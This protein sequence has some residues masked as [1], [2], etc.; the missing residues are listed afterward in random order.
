MIASHG[1]RTTSR[2]GSETDSTPRPGAA[3]PGSETRV[4]VRGPNKLGLDSEITAMIRAGP[5]S[6][7]AAEH[8]A[9]SFRGPAACRRGL[10]PVMVAGAGLSERLGVGMNLNP[11]L[12]LNPS[13]PVDSESSFKLTRS[14]S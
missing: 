10:F 3:G 9:C 6:A 14:R 11:G 2:P 4:R 8:H 1:V 13:C 7:V 5:G 12:G